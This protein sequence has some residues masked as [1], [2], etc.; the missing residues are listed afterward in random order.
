MRRWLGVARG[1]YRGYVWGATY[2]GDLLLL[3]VRLYWG[4]ML[5]RSGWEKFNNLDAT[6]QFFDSL[7]II[8]PRFN[9]VVSGCVEFGCGLLLVIGLAARIA[10]LPLVINML[11]A[12][13]MASRDRL[14]AIF[15]SP[16][17]FVTAPEFLYLFACLLVVAFGPGVVSVDALACILLGRLP[18]DG[19]A[20]RDLLKAQ[21]V[22]SLSSTISHGRREFAKLAAA[23]AAGLCAGLLLRFGGGGPAKDRA[24]EKPSGAA[25]AKT[26]VPAMSNATLPAAPPG[27]DLALLMKG[28]PHVCRGLN[29][30]KGTGKDHKNACAGQ[31]AC[32][33][34]ESHACN[35]LND[36]KGQGGCDGTAGIN[37]CKGKGAC[38]VPLKD[39]TWK[40]ARARFE[41]L[42]AKQH[43]KIG[44]APAA[45]KSG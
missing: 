43:K 19:A 31:G 36:C 17:D 30:C 15:S 12:F 10:A 33:T 28:D 45:E 3:A 8:W 23:A 1:F 34:A 9:A 21:N 20:A 38:A 24:A 37:Q 14:F 13:A 18:A 32:A 7:H 16:N 27:T 25:G 40:L 41:Q 22:S 29:T 39:E 11:V 26:N 35:G 6:A 42:A 5:V 44:A 4:S 2:L